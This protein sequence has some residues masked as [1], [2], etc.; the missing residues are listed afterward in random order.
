MSLFDRLCEY[1]LK[2]LTPASKNRSILPPPFQL[3][4]NHLIQIR[5]VFK[6]RILFGEKNGCADEQEQRHRDAKKYAVEQGFPFQGSEED[7]GRDN[8][9]Q[10]N[11]RQQAI[12]QAQDV[13]RLLIQFTEHTMQFVRGEMLRT[14]LQHHA[15]IIVGLQLDA[16]QALFNPPF[17]LCIA[18]LLQDEHGFDCLR[19]APQTLKSGNSSLE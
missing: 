16:L 12:A 9:Q 11:A 1:E 2:V 17:A 13:A 7:D 18:A 3:L 10:Q 14:K 4:M 19:N 8:K 5:R 15:Q 6:G